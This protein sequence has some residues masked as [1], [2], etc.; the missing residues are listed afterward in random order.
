[1]SKKNRISKLSIAGFKSLRS[2]PDFELGNLN[3][4]LGANG[5]GKSGFVSYFRMLGEMVEG[6]LQKW[7]APTDLPPYGRWRIRPGVEHCLAHQLVRYSLGKAVA[8][9]LACLQTDHDGQVQPAF[10]G[11][12][13][14]DLADPSRSGTAHGKTDSW[15]LAEYAG[16]P[17]FA[18]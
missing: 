11:R 8:E 10:P 14:G 1:M 9:H 6:R 12:D 3:V 4:L 5:A 15:S 16:C 2:L 17:S 13:V 7:T 18:A